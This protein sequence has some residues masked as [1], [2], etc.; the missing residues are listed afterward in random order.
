M[1]INRCDAVADQICYMGFL[2]AYHGF[3]QGVSFGKIRGSMIAVSKCIHEFYLPGSVRSQ[4][5]VFDYAILGRLLQRYADHMFFPVHNDSVPI[6]PPA[7]DEVHSVQ[8]NK[9]VDGVDQLEIADIGEQ[10]GLHDGN[11]QGLIPFSLRC[12]Q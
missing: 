12:H 5:E 1:V 8:Q 4:A 10:I 3:N 9:F 11:F 7:V 6:D 2:T